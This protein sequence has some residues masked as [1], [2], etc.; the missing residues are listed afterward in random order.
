VII[1]FCLVFPQIFLLHKVVR[2]AKKVEKH[3]SKRAVTKLSDGRASVSSSQH[4]HVVW[5]TPASQF[6]IARVAN[7]PISLSCYSCATIGREYRVHGQFCHF[8]YFNIRSDVFREFWFL[9]DETDVD[10]FWFLHF[11]PFQDQNKSDA[12]LSSISNLQGCLVI[13]P[14]WSSL[15]CVE[16]DI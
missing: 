1:K 4:P 7:F 3:C 16:N 6:Q 8:W 10:S 14:N 15:H 12:F 5:L 2:D 11:L 13:V 9:S